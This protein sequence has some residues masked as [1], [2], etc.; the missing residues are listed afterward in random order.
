MARFI[1]S[2]L[3]KRSVEIGS[4]VDSAHENPVPAH[5][6]YELDAPEAWEF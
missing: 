5:V 6:G 4:E 3:V 2:T 1:P